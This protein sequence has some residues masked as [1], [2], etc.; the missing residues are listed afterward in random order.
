M[1]NNIFER[2]DMLKY[3]DEFSEIYNNRI[4][5]NNEGGMKSPHLFPIWYILKK[6]KPKYIIES[7]VW[8]GLGTWFFE[9]ASP[10]SIIIS[11]DPSPNY[12]I[13]TSPNVEYSTID[14]INYDWSKISD[15]DKK[16]TLLFFDDHQNSIDRIKHAKLLGFKKMIFED[17]YPYLQGDCYSP[18]KILSR[19]KWVIDLG[20]V[21]KW[22]DPVETDYNYFI[23]NVISYQE[24]PPLFKDD[25]TRWGDDWSDYI[26]NTP[27]PLLSKSDIEKYPIFFD[28]RKDYT[29]LSY[30]EI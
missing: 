3:L 23:E 21:K 9:N 12:R 14:F 29:W 22:F 15:Q 10:D 1:K 7:G 4:I 18:K 24:L 26:Y 13:Y 16:D 25:K 30:L 2:E 27:E 11:I 17:N 19:K 28:E 5:N 20:G 6:I 8:K